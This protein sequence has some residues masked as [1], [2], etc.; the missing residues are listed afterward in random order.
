M[1]T[2]DAMLPPG[3]RRA[4]STQGP[5]EPL[6][7]EDANGTRE[8]GVALCWAPGPHEPTRLFAAR[9]QTDR[10]TWSPRPCRQLGVRTLIVPGLVRTWIQQASR[11][12]VRRQHGEGVRNTRTR[13]ASVSLLAGQTAQPDSRLLEGFGCVTLKVFWGL[14]CPTEIVS[15]WGCTQVPG[16]EPVLSPFCTLTPGDTWCVIQQDAFTSMDL[17]SS[18]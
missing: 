7:D 9:T 5:R 2:Q 18:G 17:S 8:G 4:V 13:K 14:C 15:V 6:R 1:T 12:G 10:L 16:H 11:S 3:E